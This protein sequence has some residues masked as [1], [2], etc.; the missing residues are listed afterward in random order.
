MATTLVPDKTIATLRSIQ[1]KP[2]R[3]E[4]RKFPEAV[5]E[6]VDPTTAKRYL[7]ANVHNRD[8]RDARVRTH[9]ATLMREEWRA[10][11]N[12]I[13]F[14]TDGRLIDGQ[15]R[16]SAIILADTPALLIVAR[17]LPPEAQDVT[18]QGIPRKMSDA[19]KL[20]GEKDWFALAAALGWLYRLDFIAQ[21]GEVHYNAG[22]GAMRP[23]TPQLLR[24]LDKNPLIRTRVTRTKSVRKEIPIRTG[25]FAALWLKM[26][27][28]APEHADV[29]VDAL[30]SGVIQY[31]GDEEEASLRPGDPINALRRLLMQRQIRE[32]EKYP[33]Y[34][35]A[36]LISKAFILWI[37][38]AQQVGT[39]AWKYGGK[40]REAFPI[41][42]GPQS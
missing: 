36:A 40:Q 22:T 30:A 15:H 24:V 37:D 34:V 10:T 6:L 12:G 23:N 35:E 3:S 39:L 31:E 18:D 42:R 8:L 32:R 33:D 16:L 19:L 38:G 26:L 20:R 17:G 9:A 41:I 28:A 25:L 7:Q 2:L 1:P 11:P 14:D 27:Y 21:T 13:G 5:F 29:F 4:R